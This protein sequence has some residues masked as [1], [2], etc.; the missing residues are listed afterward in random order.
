M[1]RPLRAVVRAARLPQP[2]PRLASLLIR[3]DF[4]GLLIQRPKRLVLRRAARVPRVLPLPLPL[5]PLPLIPL[6]LIALRLLQHALRAARAVT[7]PP[8]PRRVP[9][10]GQ[11]KDGQ[12][13]Y[14]RHVHL[15]DRR[16][17]VVISLTSRPKT[18][19]D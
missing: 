9:S 16:K 4:E 19:E 13:L 14:E 18:E 6:P 10:L 3:V 15:V 2:S 11:P 8:P 17:Q 1:R 7:P 12:Q 5:I